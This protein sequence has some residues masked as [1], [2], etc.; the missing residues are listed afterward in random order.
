M[1]KN[2][3]EL[4]D[5]FEKI[6]KNTLKNE[7]ISKINFIPTGW[8]NIV[9]EVETE[10][11]NFFFRFPRDEFWS[12]VIVKDYEFAKY[13]CGKTSFN[14]VQLDI[15]FDESRPFSRHKKIPGVTL[16]EK[17]DELSDV[18]VESVSSEIA[19][20]M[21]E[22]HNVNYDENKIFTVK[23]ISHK[24][25]GFLEEL[26]NLHVNKEDKKFWDNYQETATECLVHGDLNSSN[27]LLDN[28]N[29]VTAVI[30]FGFAGFGDKYDDISRIIGRCPTNFKDKI[31][32]NYERYLN[33]SID[34]DKLENK[35]K[36][37]SDIDK[38]YIN[39]M[40]K[41]GIYK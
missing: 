24:L 36:M 4:D 13:I 27:I 19:R 10:S 30:D 31:I 5:D 38:G 35:I 37:W 34:M 12:R 14:T 40:R 16:A 1:N 17:M 2:Y 11:G 32:K 22:L 21:Y 29:H 23:N 3:F 8:T 25:H 9:Y 41:I 15:F 7:N 26:L 18:E 20:F 28:N 33:N 6:I 39:Y